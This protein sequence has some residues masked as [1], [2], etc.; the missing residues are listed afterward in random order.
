MLMSGGTSCIP[1]VVAGGIVGTV[2]DVKVYIV[3]QV[4]NAN[5][6]L[7]L[8][9]TLVLLESGSVDQICFRSKTALQNLVFLSG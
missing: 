3:F 9:S 7:S 6:Q 5:I 2:R 1:G 8:F 4:A